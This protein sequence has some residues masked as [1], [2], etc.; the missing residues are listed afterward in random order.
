M[1]RLSNEKDTRPVILSAVHYTYFGSLSI[2]ITITAIVIFSYTAAAPSE[3]DLYGVTWWTRVD[4][5]RNR[6]EEEG[7]EEEEAIGNNSMEMKGM[8]SHRE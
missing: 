5:K 7:E 8:N 6:Q 3:E 4:L 1:I 2:L